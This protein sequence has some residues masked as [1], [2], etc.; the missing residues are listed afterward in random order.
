MRVKGGVV[1]I[2]ISRFD[3]DELII[4]PIQ[5]ITDK[6]L[7]FVFVVN[8]PREE[9]NLFLNSLVRRNDDDIPIRIEDL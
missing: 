1:H 8:P 4:R 6:H 5:E 9:F 3:F 2:H 7:F